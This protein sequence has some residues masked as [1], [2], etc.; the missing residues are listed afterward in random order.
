MDE[1]DLVKGHVIGK[2]AILLP[3][4]TIT[5]GHPQSPT[6]PDGHLHP[7]DLRGLRIASTSEDAVCLQEVAGKKVIALVLLETRGVMALDESQC[8]EGVDTP[9]LLITGADLWRV[10]EETRPLLDSTWSVAE[11]H[12]GG[13]GVEVGG[14]LKLSVFV[15]FRLSPRVQCLC[16][17]KE[18]HENSKPA[19]EAIRGDL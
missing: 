17:S 13:G 12:P 9:R 15:C 18:S 6:D 1:T 7:T 19:Q 10:D 4:L 16:H 5:D 3:D 2:V 14:G 8:V 11:V